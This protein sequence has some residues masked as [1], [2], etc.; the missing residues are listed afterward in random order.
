MLGLGLHFTIAFT[1]ATFYYLASRKLPVLLEHAILCGLLYGEIVF[2]FMNF[3]VLPL[4]ALGADQFNITTY[5]TGTI[6]HPLLVGL[7]IALS[8]RHWSR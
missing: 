5:I 7:P 4:S 3:V 8:V 6:G 1:A 2:L